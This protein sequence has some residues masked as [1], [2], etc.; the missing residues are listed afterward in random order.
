M[1]ERFGST[2]QSL[3]A[4]SNLR[5]YLCY[6]GVKPEVRPGGR[7]LWLAEPIL[8]ATARRTRSVKQRTR[9]VKQ[10]TQ[11]RADLI[12]EV[13]QPRR[14]GVSTGDITLR[15][16]SL[17]LRRRLGRWIPITQEEAEEGQTM[18]TGA[19]RHPEPYETAEQQ[20]DLPAPAE[21][22]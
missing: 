13:S 17:R 7:R 3:R 15:F 21:E 11:V 22:H 12:N 4:S 6:P 16:T 8:K 20:R 5:L 14:G 18:R 9:S 19:E 1:R 2:S 10:R